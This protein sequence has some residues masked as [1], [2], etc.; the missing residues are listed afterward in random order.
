MVRFFQKMHMSRVIDDGH[1]PFSAH[2]WDRWT[3]SRQ[4]K[5]SLAC[6]S[7]SD[8]RRIAEKYVM[9]SEGVCYEI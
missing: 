2:I 7:T 9:E 5:A 3:K 6:V 4:N 1:R 8:D